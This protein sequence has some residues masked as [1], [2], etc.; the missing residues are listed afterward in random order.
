[1]NLWDRESDSAYSGMDL[2]GLVAFRMSL[3]LYG[4]LVRT[5][6]QVVLPFC[7]HCCFDDHLD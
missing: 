6:F 7:L 3:S 4:I 1:M 2:L 5:S